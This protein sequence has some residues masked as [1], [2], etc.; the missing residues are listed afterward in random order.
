[1]DGGSPAAELV[2][3]EDT[4]PAAPWSTLSCT[5]LRLQP[6]ASAA[7][8]RDGVCV[9]LAK[10]RATQQILPISVGTQAIAEPERTGA[11]RRAAACAGFTKVTNRAASWSTDG[12]RAELGAEYRRIDDANYGSG[13]DRAQTLAFFPH[14]TA[15]G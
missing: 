13:T 4:A 3:G 1:M 10:S 12:V 9:A 11:A 7:Q 8:R 15:T 2:C 5:P 14:R 6:R